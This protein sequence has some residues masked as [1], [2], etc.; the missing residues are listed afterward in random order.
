MTG[1]ANEKDADLQGQPEL[2]ARSS[3]PPDDRSAGADNPLLRVVEAT[4][5][6]GALVAVDGVSLS[7]ELGEKHAILGPNGS[8]KTTLFN[9]IT[10]DYPLTSGRIFLDGQEISDWSMHRR[11]R[12][13]LRR[14]YQNTLLFSNLTVF[15]NLFLSLQGV[16]NSRFSFRRVDTY[17]AVRVQ[18]ES[19][20][21]QLH[22]SE[23]LSTVV[24]D[25]SHGHQRLV[26]IGMAL[27]GEPKVILLDE[28]VAGLSNEERPL[29]P[30]VLGSLP[31]T[32]TMVMI[33]HDMD[34]A[35]QFADYVTVLHNGKAIR[36]R[37]TVEEI[38]SDR[39]IQDL[40]VGNA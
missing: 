35:L 5:A 6:F 18:V 29:I 15:E 36:E 39:Y 37:A 3:S 33:E 40:Y 10:G 26:E 28:P 11:I 4:K 20:A 34:I 14:T 23:F 7:V 1:D 25:M 21:Q 38:K 8:G 16:S 19:I 13:G 24:G 27:A 32:I 31:E 12:R 30:K 22:I 17:D 2:D 9:I